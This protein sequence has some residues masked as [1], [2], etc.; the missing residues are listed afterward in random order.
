MDSNSALK[1]PSPKPSSPLR[2]MNSKNTGPSWFSEKIC[3]SSSPRVAVDQDFALSQLLERLAVARDALVDE[4]VVGVRRL[5]QLHARR[6]S[7]HPRC[8]RG[9]SIPARCAGCPRRGSGRGIP[10]SARPFPVP[11]SLIGMRILPQGLVIALRLDAGD[12]ALDVEVAHLAEIEQALVDSPPI[13]S[14]AR[15]AR[16]ASGGR[17]T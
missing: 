17:C 3:S 15:D 4:L 1:L 12:L 16:C 11:S 2:W 13:R 7:A 10:G 14:C 5:E 6:A 8:G 9:R